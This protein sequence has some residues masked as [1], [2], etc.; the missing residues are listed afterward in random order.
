MEKSSPKDI[1]LLHE[2]QKWSISY[3]KKAN[4]LYQAIKYKCEQKDDLTLLAEDFAYLKLLR[5]KCH[6]FAKPIELTIKLENKDTLVQHIFSKKEEVLPNLDQMKEVLNTSLDAIAT[7]NREGLVVSSLMT[8]CKGSKISICLVRDEKLTLINSWVIAIIR[9]IT[10]IAPKVMSAKFKNSHYNIKEGI[11]DIKDK[12]IKDILSK[13][14]STKDFNEF[15]IHAKRQLNPSSFTN[16]IK[17]DMAMNISKDTNIVLNMDKSNELRKD[18]LLHNKIKEV[19]KFIAESAKAP[20]SDPKIIESSFEK[21]ASLKGFRLCKLIYKAIAGYNS[22]NLDP[23]F[24]K[25]AHCNQIESIELVNCRLEGIKDS[26]ILR[27]P[28][29]ALSFS[30]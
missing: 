4:K 8:S 19:M 9:I 7:I 29:I 10:Q 6:A 22:D 13:G 14:Y 18:L 21:G 30:T 1:E 3:I 23:L 11:S 26:T 16:I 28:I 12:L 27:S 15:Y 20:L 17:E 2:D 24:K 25:M 5:K